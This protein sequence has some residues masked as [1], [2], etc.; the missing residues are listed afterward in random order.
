MNTYRNDKY[1]IT[2]SLNDRAIHIKI[3]NSLSY[4]FYEGNFDGAAF[5][6]PFELKD[7]YELINK[8]FAR[9][10]ENPND[11]KYSVAMELDN[12][13]LLVRFHCVVEGFL[14]V[15]FDLRMREKIMSNDAQLTVNFQRQQQTIELLMQRVEQMEKIISG[16]GAEIHL[17]RP[18]AQSPTSYQIS[19]TA[20]TISA[21][22]YT[23]DS[24]KK[25]KH[26]YKLDSLTF[27]GLDMT[28]GPQTQI[29]N[30]FVKK[31]TVTSCP[32]FAN[33]ECIK[34]F[35]NV[36][37]LTMTNCTLS[38]NSEN[39]LKQS[40]HKLKKIRLTNYGTAFNV[41][42]LQRYCTEN[43]IELTLA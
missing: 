5:K 9:F 14:T 25:I 38:A 24:Y 36:E 15:S 39:V 4:A 17:A 19:E 26:F 23:T 8:C 35:P 28:N 18:G 3:A 34:N 31:L 37:E 43:R 29:T 22:P 21:P 42:E 16:L 27:S 10:V 32:A 6:H 7:T 41:A 1:T 12:S 20:L 2:T 40:K 33:L 13:T 11:K 30:A